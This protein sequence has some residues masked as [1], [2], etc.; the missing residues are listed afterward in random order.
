MRDSLDHCVKCTI[1]ETHCPVAA[2]TPL[3]P[4]PKFVGPQAERY[5]VARRPVAGRVPRLLLELRHLHPGVPAGRED[6]GDQQPGPRAAQGG[7]RRP[8]AR[9]AHRA[10]HPGGAP[11]VAGRAARQLE[12]ARAAAAGGAGEDAGDP[13]RRPHARVAGRAFQPLGAPQRARGQARPGAGE[14]DGRV[15]PR[16]R[17]Q[18][19]RAR[20]RP[21][22]DGGARAPGPRGDR[23]RARDAAACR[24]RATACSTMRAA[25]SAAWR[26]SSRRTPAP[27]TTSCRAPPAAG[28][29]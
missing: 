19:L 10:P 24:C 1:C 18:L 16:L 14:P 15:L 3:F 6:R 12:P 26:S 8:A 11:G 13:P 5:R 29:C 21:R 28:S 20:R 22:H 27:A 23:A 7:P 9:P 4:G 17:R 25:T 2:A